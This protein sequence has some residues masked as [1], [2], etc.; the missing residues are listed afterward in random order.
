M[1]PTSLATSILSVNVKRQV[2]FLRFPYWP[3]CDCPVI[4]FLFLLIS[5]TDRLDGGETFFFFLVWVQQARCHLLLFLSVVL[6]RQADAHTHVLVCV[7]AMLKRESFFG[8]RERK[9]GGGSWVVL[10]LCGRVF[11][12]ATLTTT[13]VV[14]VLFCFLI[15]SGPKLPTGGTQQEEEEEE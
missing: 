14:L 1:S 5:R 2:S 9:K 8:W 3:G 4:L 6:L 12:E 13:F 7:Y 10:S 15:H 11:R